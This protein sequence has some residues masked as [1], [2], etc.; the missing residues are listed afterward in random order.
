MTCAICPVLI[1]V[2]RYG[3]VY[4]S[5]WG[6]VFGGGGGGNGEYYLLP[7][8]NERLWWD[9]GIGARD[10]GCRTTYYFNN[11]VLIGLL[12]FLLTIIQQNDY[13]SYDGERS[14]IA[15]GR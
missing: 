5:L 6:S 1:L 8:E 2:L 13:L 7:N 9:W 14:W 10:C 15:G 12:N 11:K 4:F 3:N